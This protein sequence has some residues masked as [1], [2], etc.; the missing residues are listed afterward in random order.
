MLQ[1]IKEEMPGLSPE[2]ARQLASGAA[3]SLPHAGL[4]FLHL[5]SLRAGAAAPLLLQH[6]L[7]AACCC[8]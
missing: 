7:W 8:R 6:L 4:P 5:R 3:V 1:V 2:Q